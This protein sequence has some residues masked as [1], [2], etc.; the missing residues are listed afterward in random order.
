MH[1]YIYIHKDTTK[2][3]YVPL[4]IKTEKF[5]VSKLKECLVMKIEH[6]IIEQ[7]YDIKLTLRT[8]ETN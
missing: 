1:L 2:Y 5:M 4:Q 8:K 7:T 6:K 3:A